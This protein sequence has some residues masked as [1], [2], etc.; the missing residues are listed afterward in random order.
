MPAE[1]ECD[2]AALAPEIFHR[3]IQC[4]RSPAK[5]WANN[6]GIPPAPRLSVFKVSVIAAQVARGAGRKSVRG[7][8]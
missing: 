2:R 7:R 8:R 5:E 6:T 3:G 1:I 4:E